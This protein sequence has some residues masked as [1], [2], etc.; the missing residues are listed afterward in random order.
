MKLGLEFERLLKL[1]HLQLVKPSE[2]IKTIPFKNGGLFVRALR[3]HQGIITHVFDQTSTYI[4]DTFHSQNFCFD[5]L[6]E[7]I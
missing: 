5:S 4:D 2:R 3:C 6:M 7:R 1:G